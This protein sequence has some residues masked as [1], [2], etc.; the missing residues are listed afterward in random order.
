VVLISVNYLG[1]ISQV[2]KVTVYFKRNMEKLSLLQE[3][4][5]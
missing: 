3:S 4:L 1:I 2:L 5:A